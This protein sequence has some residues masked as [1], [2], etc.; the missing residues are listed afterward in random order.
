M[1]ESFSLKIRKK[2][3]IPA[4]ATC[5]QQCSG[6]LARAIKH[7]KKKTIQIQKKEELSLSTDDMML[8]TENPRESTEKKINY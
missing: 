4:F 5:I 2:K 3:R 6:D 7:G 8:N 1:T